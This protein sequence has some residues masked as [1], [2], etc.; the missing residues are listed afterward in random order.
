M[1]VPPRGTP[2]RDGSPPRLASVCAGRKRRH[3]PWHAP[4][5][6]RGRPK[7][8]RRSPPLRHPPGQTARGPARPTPAPLQPIYR[9]AGHPFRFPSPAAL[10]SQFLCRGC[11]GGAIYRRDMRPRR[12]FGGLA[13]GEKLAHRARMTLPPPTLCARPSVVICLLLY[14]ATTQQSAN[15]MAGEPRS[16]AARKWPPWPLCFPVD[17]PPLSSYC[18]TCRQRANQPPGQSSNAR[19]RT[20][21]DPRIIQLSQSQT[22]E[23][24]FSPS[25]TV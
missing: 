22:L 2:G 5:P 16:F 23:F 14:F 25:L 15:S 1:P 8:C 17:L 10:T 4:T 19:C 7:H 3:A 6:A 11:Q 9:Q 12:F 24:Q 18:S 21:S 20:V 13:G